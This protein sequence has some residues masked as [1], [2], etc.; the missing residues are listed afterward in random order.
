[1][2]VIIFVMFM[3]IPTGLIVAGIIDLITGE[4]AGDSLGA[5]IMIFFGVLIWLIVIGFMMGSLG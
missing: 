3:L 1:M 4:I 5:S 2:K